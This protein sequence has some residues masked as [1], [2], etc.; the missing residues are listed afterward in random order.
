MRRE[1]PIQ[2]LV[3]RLQPVVVLTLLELVFIESF[4][5]AE[6]ARAHEP[7]GQPSIG[8]RWSLAQSLPELLRVMPIKV[9]ETD[10]SV[11]R[12]FDRF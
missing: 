7:P 12:E 1:C 10:D 11:A 3:Y 6:D 8:R 5:L 2:V 4:A 9:L